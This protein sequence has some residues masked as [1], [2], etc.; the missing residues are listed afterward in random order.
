M[1]GYASG[2]QPDD[3]KT[4]KLNTNENP[5][6]ASPAVSEVINTLS[7][8]SLRRYP[9]PTADDFRQAAAKVHGVKPSNIIAT[10]GGDELLRLVITTFVDPGQTIAMSEPTYSL[11]PVLA[12]VQN[13]PVFKVKLDS[14]WSIPQNFCE[15]VNQA[16]AKLTFVVNPHAPSGYLLSADRIRDIV[17][18]INGIVL[19]DE[20]YVDFIDP[21]LKYECLSLIDEFNNLI[22]LRTLSKGYSLAGLRFGYGIAHAELIQPMV[23][24]TRDSYNLDL[25]SQ[26][27]AAAA[28]Q[29]QDYAQ[30]NWSKVRLERTLLTEKLLN[31]GFIV[32]PSEANFLLCTVPPSLTAPVLYEY[33][34][35]Q[36]IFVRYFEAERLENKLRIT[37]GTPEE[38]EALLLAITNRLRSS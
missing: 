38:N 27:I 32:E 13:C 22:F 29:D 24:K 8:A 23:E 16:K 33:L 4:I 10:R 11:Y 25:F 28:I 17:A 12:Q 9:P 1:Q 37:V 34:K 20:A 35:S 19:I 6:P 21:S 7:A 36:A 31:L 5:Y 3:D 15:K 26:Q 14:D 30:N 18:N 2:E